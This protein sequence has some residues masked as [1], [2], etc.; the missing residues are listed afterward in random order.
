M[1]VIILSTP[2]GPT[3]LVNPMLDE[4]P[5]PRAEVLVTELGP[6]VARVTVWR[7]AAGIEMRVRGAIDVPT[8]GALSEIDIEV[9]Y[10]VP[11]TYRAE[12]WSASGE[13]LGNISSEPVTLPVVDTWIHNPLDP[14]GATKVKVRSTAAAVLSRPANVTFARP[15][16][17]RVA[18]PLAEPRSGLQ[19]LS[20]DVWAP[21]EETA[22]RVQA[23]IGSPDRDLPP[24]LCI[25]V[26][27]RD[28][29]MRIPKPLFLGVQS[30]DEVDVSVQTDA[31]G[32]TWQQI[33][34]DE[35]APPVPGL[36]IPLLTWADL[37]AYFPTF[38]DLEAAHATFGDID[39]RYDLAGYA[40][41]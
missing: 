23:M 33:V 21:D 25:R 18:V 26:G 41:Q 24:V 31:G 8:A 7:S 20:F 15:I 30:I 38:G 22:A 17:R 14:R 9:P 11:V 36:S 37:E 27:T 16:G 5:C 34:G 28:G 13:S 40:Q 19:G 10:G 35:V 4:A 12:L 1:S 2:S 39:R 29:R 3:V 6:E 32:A